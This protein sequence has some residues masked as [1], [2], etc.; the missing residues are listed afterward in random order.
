LLVFLIANFFV[1]S[2]ALQEYPEPEI[3]PEDSD[4][5]LVS[6][7]ETPLA[8]SSPTLVGFFVCRRNHLLPRSFSSHSLLPFTASEATFFVE[9]S[10]TSAINRRGG[11]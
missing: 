8:Q 5:I 2:W 11:V 6:Q 4:S 9:V 10:F 3:I 7:H 1:W